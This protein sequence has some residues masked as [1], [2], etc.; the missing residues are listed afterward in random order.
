MLPRVT[1]TQHWSCDPAYQ[2]V[3]CVKILLLLLLFKSTPSSRQRTTEPAEKESNKREPQSTHAKPHGR[4]TK[5][6]SKGEP[7]G[8]AKEETQISK[9]SHKYDSKRAAAKV[10]R[11]RAENGI[12]KR[13][14]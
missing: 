14:P 9:E 10:P 12:R 8:K 7:Q 6:R 3:Q 13:E 1:K 5:V 11:T 4:A 2:I